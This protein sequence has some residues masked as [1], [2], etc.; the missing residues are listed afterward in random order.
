MEYMEYTRSPGGLHQDSLW[1]PHGVHM[2]YV[3]YTRSLEGVHMESMA[4]CGGEGA[5]GQAHTL[6]VVALPVVALVVHPRLH[7]GPCHRHR[8]PAHLSL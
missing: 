4:T 1:S 6:F 2:E 3:E 7:P 8:W 5:R